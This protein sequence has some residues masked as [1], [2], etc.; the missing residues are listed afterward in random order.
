M[1]ELSIQAGMEASRGTGMVTDL[2]GQAGAFTTLTNTLLFVVGALSVLMIILGGMRY[3]LSGG[4]ATSVTA[5]KNTIL[6][7]VVGL[8]VCIFAYSIIAFVIDSFTGSSL[9]L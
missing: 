9:N 5:A 1:Q 2:L 3:V 6:Y 4:N 7:A 8:M